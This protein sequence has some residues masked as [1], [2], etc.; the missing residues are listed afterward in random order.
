MK[1]MKVPDTLVTA[2]V[3]FMRECKGQPWFVQLYDFLDTSHKF[4]LLLELCDGGNL[5]DAARSLNDG[6]SEARCAA[7]MQQLL[8][9]IAFLHSRKICHR[10]I[11]PQ[12]AML[13]GDARDSS[14]RL[15]L[16]DFGIAVRL[17]EKLLTEKLGTPAFMAP[18][19]HMLPKSNGYD[20]KVDLWAAGTFMVFLLSLEYPFVDPS[21]RLLKNDLLRGDL[22]IWEGNAFQ[23]LFRNV[24]EAAGLRRKRPSPVA[25]DLVRRL[26]RPKRTLRPEAEEALKHPWFRAPPLEPGDQR[27]DDAHD[28]LLQ[29]ADF[30]DG[31]AAISREFQRKAQEMVEAVGE[32]QIGINLPEPHIQLDLQDDR[33]RKCVVCYQSSGHF[34]FYC[35]QCYHSVCIG[36]LVKLPKPECPHCRKP[37]SDVAAAQHLAKVAENFDAKAALQVAIQVGAEV[38]DNLDKVGS[39]AVLDLSL[40][41]H[42]TE[43]DR[44]RGRACCLCQEPSSATNHV[45]PACHA[46]ICYTCAR[47][48]L[49]ERRCPA[50]GDVEKNAE[51]LRHYLA[52][53]EAWE[54]AMGLA[55]RAG[56]ALN[57]V[58]A[59]A[60][61]AFSSDGSPM[62]LHTEDQAALRRTISRQAQ[63]QVSH[64][65]FKCSAPSSSFDLAC[66]KCSVALCSACVG[67]LG[68]RPCCPGC[69]DTEV[70]NV[71]AVR[72]HQS[73]QQITTS[74]ASLWEGILYLG[75][76]LLESSPQ[77]SPVAADASSGPGKPRLLAPAATAHRSL[78]HAGDAQNIEDEVAMELHSEKL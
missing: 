19:M 76:E 73:A 39:G 71:A 36:C 20:C 12:N 72:F 68:E 33:M 32:I 23:S 49:S 75:K 4:Y 18:E 45:C 66:S 22:P 48:E 7:F 78:P 27:E 37:A 52:A 17:G 42:A 59:F 50:C 10:D 61:R 28:P 55:N 34:G 70:F 41:R 54:A 57:E 26:L 44:E 29:W 9:G 77:G 40:P 5:E 30:E 64:C 62:I 16:G 14:S 58:E 6:L 11:K 24:Q 3:E 56:E 15:R 35:D 38:A 1:Q 31:F 8:S 65:C 25:R 21:G 69:K 13:L 47:T 43:R 63:L 2:E 53:G 67:R 46:S 51:P 74:A 60:T